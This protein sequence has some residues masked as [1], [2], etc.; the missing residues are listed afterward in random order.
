MAAGV[1]V[2]N[3]D[4]VD[5]MDLEILDG[6]LFQP[7]STPTVR[8]QVVLSSTWH[9]PDKTMAEVL[10]RAKKQDWPVYSWCF[11]ETLQPHGWLH[12]REVEETRHSTSAERFAIEVE[13]QEPSVEGRA[14]D[15][16]ALRRMFDRKYGEYRGDPD[17]PAQVDAKEKAKLLHMWVCAH[18]S[19]WADIRDWTIFM[20]LRV[21][22]RPFRIVHWVRYGRTGGYK[23]KIDRW[24]ELL[25]QM[26]GA[27]RHD[28]GGPAEGF[29]DRLHPSSEGVKITGANKADILH[30]YVAAIERGEIVGPYIDYAF[31]EH[32]YATHGSL[33][34][35][36][37]SQHTPDSII[38]GAMAYR[39][40]KSMVGVTEGLAVPETL[41]RKAPW[42]IES[43]A[44][45]MLTGQEQEDE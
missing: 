39:A 43:E 1:V 5:E 31:Q 15:G 16:D 22:C 36:A 34:G 28:A 17:V 45:F 7:M 11:K 6:A 14:I 10:K 32:Y 30:D 41:K 9:Y 42:R 12:P 33:Y 26:P 35:G 4:E 24:N 38:A 21:D 13:L 19:D 27:A 23:E 20:T 8:K 3:C 2:H 18:G 44:P 25:E 40:A 29:N 37:G